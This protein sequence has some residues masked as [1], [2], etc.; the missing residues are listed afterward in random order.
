[1]LDY[2][3]LNTLNGMWFE[4]DTDLLITAMNVHLAYFILFYS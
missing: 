3:I 4:Q 1:M 2:T